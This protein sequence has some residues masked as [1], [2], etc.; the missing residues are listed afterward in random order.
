LVGVGVEIIAPEREPEPWA[1]DPEL[2]AAAVMEQSAQQLFDAAT[3]AWMDALRR[4]AEHRIGASEHW[5]DPVKGWVTRGNQTAYRRLSEAEDRARRHRD[6][7]GEALRAARVAHAEAI[8]AAPA[9]YQTRQRLLPYFLGTPCSRCGQLMTASDDLA[10][11]RT[12]PL[13]VDP[14]SRLDR[15]VHAGCTQLAVAR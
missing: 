6:E 4:L 7:I 9:A 12:V 15:L 14:R 1:D 3:D 10:L 5:F 13:A 8:R 11:G 2:L